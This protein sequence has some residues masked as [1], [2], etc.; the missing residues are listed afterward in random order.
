M[1]AGMTI[2]I[3][4]T[5]EKAQAKRDD[6]LK[7][8]D[9]EGALALFGGWTGA[10]LST[11]SDDEDFRFVKLPAVQSMVSRWSDTVPGSEGLKWNKSRIAD[12]LLLGGVIPKIIGSPTTVV[13]ELERWV[14][15]GQID[16]FNLVHIVNPGS[17]DDM[18]EFLLP[19]LRKRGLFGQKKQKEGA[20]AREV[21]LG[22][23]HVL[24]D[25]PAFQFKWVD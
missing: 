2:I 7:Y 24:S 6:F 8:G 9:R 4:E 20:T 1:I 21:F 22:Q 17:Y 16:G 23:S 25:H 5:D 11:Y 10:D 15:I 3:D 14:E 19:E 18:I 13:D 12:Y